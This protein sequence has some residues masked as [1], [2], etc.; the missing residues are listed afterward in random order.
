MTLERLRTVFRPYCAPL[1]AGIVLTAFGRIEAG[2]IN[3]RSPSFVDVSAAIGLAADGDT[4]VVPAGTATWSSTLFVTK[5]ITL[6]GATTTDTRAGTVNDQTIILDN[7]QRTSSQSSIIQV[8]SS[9][10]QSFR[11]TGF[12]F[13]PS[14]LTTMANP[15]AVRLGGTC[16]SVRV[17]HCH[18]DRLYQTDCIH[19]YGCIFGVVDHC[20]FDCGSQRL[21]F[22]VWHQSWGGKSY[23]DGSW[24]DPPYFGS[25]K[26]LFIEDNI[27]NNLSSSQIY[28]GIDAK[29]GARY[30]A[31]YNKFNNTK[32]G[33]HGTEGG[34][35]RGCRAMEIYNNTFNWTMGNNGGICRSGTVLLHNN[36]F[37]GTKPSHGMSFQA[38]REFAPYPPWRGANGH[39]AWDVNDSHGLYLS[40]K[41]TGPNASST[42]NVS[43]A[44]WTTNQWVGYQVTNTV[45][46]GN[47]HIMSN[48]SDTITPYIYTDTAKPLHFN[49]G[50]TFVIYKVLTA[51][52]QP[53][54]GQGDLLS[55]STPLN[56]V[57]NSASWPRNALEPGYSWN[58]KYGTESVYD[59]RA[60]AAQTFKENRDYY[61]DTP[62]PGYTPYTY[63]HPLITGASNGGKRPTIPS[64]K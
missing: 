22:E 6:Q 29:M 33:N 7:V 21:A 1:V 49:T 56:R 14:T 61:N 3:A 36:T 64:G 60:G 11:L 41:H 31:R 38:F 44:N 39:N 43:T 57:T 54:R 63:P 23:G 58:N 24:A 50:D 45:S 55:G 62:K 30:V 10:T 18:F 19:T 51:L 32:P 26:F 28:C 4:I 27:F 47:S 13:R 5:G 53:G 34:R 35:Q 9:P 15:G 46:G 25:D 48:T 17:D 16:R 40:G 52:D 20:I 8:T 12:T 59:I 2:V 37:T 42:L